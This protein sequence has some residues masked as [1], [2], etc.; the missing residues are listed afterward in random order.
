MILLKGIF[1]GVYAAIYGSII[2]T[3]LSFGVH[4]LFK[5]VVDIEWSLPWINNG[6]ACV[7]A[8]VTVLIATAWPMYRLT[9]STIVDALRK[10]N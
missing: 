7:G 9:K 8:V 2:G 1:Y 3:G 6:I 4:Y 10:E 5:G